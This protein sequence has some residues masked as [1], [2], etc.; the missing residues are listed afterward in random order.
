MGLPFPS[1]GNL[2]NPE[3]QCVSPA[4]AGGFFTTEPLGKPIILNIRRIKNTG[5]LNGS[6]GKESACNAGDAG[7]HRLDAWVGRIP[8][9]GN[10]NPLQY[11]YLENPMDREA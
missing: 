11:S 5:F 9:R 7:R 4:L 3:I 8:W 1:P 6:A 10:G 2:L